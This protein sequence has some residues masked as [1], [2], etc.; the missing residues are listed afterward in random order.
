MWP[1]WYWMEFVNNVVYSIFEYDF[2][3]LFFLFLCPLKVQRVGSLLQ[4]L[5]F[6]P[7]FGEIISSI[8]HYKQI[9]VKEVQNDFMLPFLFKE[10]IS[11]IDY[12]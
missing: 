9:T 1:P 11:I 12:S 7:S 6:R 4:G 5:A 8:A 10:K 2:N 3:M